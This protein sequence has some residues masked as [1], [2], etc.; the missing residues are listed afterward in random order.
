MKEKFLKL[1]SKTR[2]KL[3]EEIYPSNYVCYGCGEEINVDNKHYLC[4]KCFASL[5]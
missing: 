1:L 4:N 2:Q 3:L 5:K